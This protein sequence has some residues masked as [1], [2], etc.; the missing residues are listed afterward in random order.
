MSRA[1][2]LSIL[3]PDCP[4]AIEQTSALHSADFLRSPKS[5]VGHQIN[6]TLFHHIMPTRKVIGLLKVWVLFSFAEHCGIV[7]YILLLLPRRSGVLFSRWLCKL[8]I[9]FMVFLKP[10]RKMSS[11]TYRFMIKMLLC[12]THF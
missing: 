1:H 6:I 7:S 8:R 5:C 4:P 2:S 3:T 12:H 11:S 9:S 10:F